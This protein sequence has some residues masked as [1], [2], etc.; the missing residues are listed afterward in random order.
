MSK[1]DGKKSFMDKITDFTT[2]LSG[3]LAKF[4]NLKSISS[5]VNGLI[6]IMPIIMVGAIFMILYV[7][8]SPSI[9]TS[10]HA[11]LPFLSPLATKFLWMNSITLGFM[12]LYA[13]IVMSQGYGER[14]GLDTKGSGLIGLGTF[15]TF[16]LA[17][18]DKSGGID[19][20]A[21]S[22]SGL[23]IGIVSSLVSVRIY[24]FFIKKNITIKMPASV[25]PNIG[26]SFAA[27]FPY[28]ASFTLAWF[29]RTI[30]NFDMLNW[31]ND[32]LEPV[33]NGSQ[34]VW[35]AMIV[36]FI[37]LLL[38]SVGLHGDNMFL[39]L[40]TPFGVTW[41]SENAKS[42]SSGTTSNHLP[43][44][45][46]GLGQT[47]LLRL[48][49]WTAAVWPV[50]FLMIIS[51]NKFLKT[52]GWTT[53]WPALFTIVEPVVFG[54][55][56]ALNPYLMIPFILSGTISTGV[57]YLLMATP[58]FGKFFAMIPW[59][60]PPFLLGPL[61]T[62]DWKTVIIPVLSFFI[63]LILYIPFWK[64]YVESLDKEAEESREVTKTN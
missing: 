36:T 37:T 49:I 2:R 47:G 59:A 44:I 43:N 24:W 13:V 45:L 10:G 39:A 27:I 51:K 3:P 56:L 63:G 33:V 46:A 48:T 18:L 57:G 54:L 20:T 53:I 55:P 60:T 50:I 34:S 15:L 5:I 40:F 4:A 52:L 26:N 21:F 29:I 8:G 41:L 28:A 12:S 58:F 6:T 42:L 32:L 25:P 30:L 31:L 23:F 64:G 35:S 14:L 17:G 61:G 19:I 38:W 11:L 62:G 7:L 22:S 9:G 1:N 16:T